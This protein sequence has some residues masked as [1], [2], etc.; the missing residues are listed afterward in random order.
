MNKFEP[1]GIPLENIAK[2][3]TLVT[4]IKYY[5]SNGPTVRQIISV[6]P[7]KYD[8]LNA[9]QSSPFVWWPEFDRHTV[10]PFL[11][12]VEDCRS[13]ALQIVEWLNAALVRGSALR[14][15][16]TIFLVER[17]MKAVKEK[18][19]PSLIKQVL[20]LEAWR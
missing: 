1:M 16:D 18:D 9:I 15:P 19:L 11:M 14:H 7:E 8:L 5:V 13:Q 17:F 4:G 20:D 6:T 10:R 2:A 12:S 3:A